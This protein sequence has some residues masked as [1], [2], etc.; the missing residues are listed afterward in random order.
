VAAVGLSGTGDEGPAVGS[1]RS[2][3]GGRQRLPR[4]ANVRPGST[5]PWAGLGPEQRR[6]IDVEA[7]RRAMSRR[8][9]S[10]PVPGAA[11]PVELPSV[12][13]RPAAVLCALFDE[14][15]EAHVVLTRRSARLRSHTGEVSFP[16]GRLEDGEAPLAAALR[17]ATEEIGLE[18]ATVEILG[19][20]SP[21]STFTNRAL[22]T[23]FVGALPARPALHPNP[24]EVERAFDVP[25]AGLVAEGVYRSELWELPVVGW[26]EMFLFDLV[27]DLVW[28][29]TARMLR[30][31]LDLIFE[32]PR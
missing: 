29:A 24:L 30:E 28:G 2:E 5:P 12:D 11:L 7:V 17:E 32:G 20:L 16:G 31:L 26:R 15:G 21:L 14:N 10:E 8:G 19:Q 22:I 25:L 4:P 9:P 23:P 3:G 1:L 27:G 13:T 18:P 6:G